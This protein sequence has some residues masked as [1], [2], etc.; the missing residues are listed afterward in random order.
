MKK[1]KKQWILTAGLS[2]L[3]GV[4]G[5][6]SSLAEGTVSS[7]SVAD[8][9]ADQAV[10]SMKAMGFVDTDGSKLKTVVLSYDR[11]IP[12]ASVTK[13]TYQVTDYGTILTE[14]DLTQGGSPGTITNMAAP[15]I[16]TTGST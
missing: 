3:L 8:L 15:A 1:I 11:D 5:G 10:T 13:D 6:F 12:S 4:G 7:P 9:G 2:V 14:K 16:I